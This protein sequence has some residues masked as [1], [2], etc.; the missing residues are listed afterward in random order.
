MCMEQWYT[1]TINTHNNTY[2]IRISNTY[3]I[4]ENDEMMVMMVLGAN[5]IIR[6]DYDKVIW[7]ALCHVR[8][9]K[10]ISACNG[11]KMLKHTTIHKSCISSSSNNSNYKIFKCLLENYE[12]FPLQI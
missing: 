3:K 4:C 5:Y 1:Y 12:L 6:N 8:T 2:N 11:C 7:S 10:L 9:Y